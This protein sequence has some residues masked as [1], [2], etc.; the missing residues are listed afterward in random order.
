MYETPKLNVVGD[1]R[2]VILGMSDT[3]EDMDGTHFPPDMEYS[4]DSKGVPRP[5][6]L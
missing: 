4:S 6:S 3:G 1:A 5:P 2:E